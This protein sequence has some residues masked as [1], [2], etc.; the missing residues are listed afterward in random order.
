MKPSRLVALITLT[1]FHPASAAERETGS[2]IG[3]KLMVEGIGA[4]M[5]LASIPDGSGRLLLAEQGGVIQ[6]LF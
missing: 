3:L 4:P 5:A 2:T 6:R 1:S